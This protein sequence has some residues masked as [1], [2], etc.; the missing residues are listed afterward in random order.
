MKKLILAIGLLSI[1]G[2]TLAAGKPC[3][4]LKA[5]IAAKL[6]AKGVSGYS[7]EIVDKGTAAGG[8]VVGTC[9]GGSKEI[10]YKK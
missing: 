4:E 6:D 1:A 8:K 3:E 10:V 9:E 5:E 7:L 2:T